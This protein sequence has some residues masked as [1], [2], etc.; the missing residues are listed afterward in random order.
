[1]K[2]VRTDLALES[3]EALLKEKQRKEEKIDGVE[4]QTSLIDDISIH[5]VRVLNDAGAKILN[6]P[7][8]LYI[9][10][11]IPRLKA[12]A[13]SVFEKGCL[14]LSHEIRNILNI[15]Q[16]DSVLVAGLGNRAIT[17]DSL[18]PKTIEN[19]M[20]TR[21]LVEY[22]PHQFG[23]KFRPVS[24]ISPGVLGIT[25]IET[26][27]ILKGIAGRATPAAVIVIDA[28]AS[29]KLSRLATT[30]Q[31]CD[32]G[33]S[34]GSGV[35]NTR[36][37]ITKDTLGM[38]VIAIGVP[39]VVDAATLTCDVLDSIIEKIPPT[40]KQE[41]KD[42]YETV[43]EALSPY[44]QNLFVTPRDIDEIINS[45]A[46]MLGYSINMSLHN[47]LSMEDMISFLS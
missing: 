7:I 30:F 36:S 17:P 13:P 19:I 23:K 12:D 37:Q 27:Q 8:G 34:P 2:T 18:G 45:V 39:T 32:T 42:N 24:A 16:G 43:F 41:L 26:S 14:V 47:E 4:V 29:R 31:L 20:V 38:P 33:I 35:G 40:K 15:K 10:I 25:G 5:R 28:L 44:E 46:K 21:H 22:M 1:M 3:H 9:T 6:K 11:E